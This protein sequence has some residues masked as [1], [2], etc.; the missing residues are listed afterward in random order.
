MTTSKRLAAFRE[1]AEDVRAEDIQTPDCPGD[2][3]RETPPEPKSRKK[4]KS[5]DEEQKAA[6][7]AA[8][9][10]GREAGF[11]SANDRM[12]AV[13]ASEHYAGREAIA[14]KMLGKASM[15]A[16]DIID[17]LASTPK[18][19]AGTSAL[20]EEEQ[21]AAAEEAGRQEMKAEL[22]KTENSKVDPNG[23]GKSEP[24]QSASKAWNNVIARMTPNKAA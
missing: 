21:R 1:R 18:E 20:T 10:E 6:L 22:G 17:V 4:E 16:E 13:F 14:A 15:T 12:N 19:A 5:M 9:T 3:D 11:K 2:E 7:D 23:N 8:R 24:K